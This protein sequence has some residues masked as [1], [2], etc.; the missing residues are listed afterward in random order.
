MFSPAAERNKEPIFKVLQPRLNQASRLL[1]IACGSLQ[2][3]CYMAPQLP[4]LEWLPTDI[5]QEALKYG[6]SLTSRPDSVA[7]PVY[8]DVHEDTWPI[9]DVDAV[10]AAN[11]L[12][13]SPASVMAALFEGCGRALRPDGAV[14]LYGP[15]KQNGRYTSPGDA[16]F[17][18]NLQ[19]RNPA[20]GI[21]NLEDVLSAAQAAG[22][23]LSEQ[24]AMPANNWLLTF[25]R[26]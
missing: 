24:T 2:H 13:I 6:Q 25:R 26:E 3:A 18:D 19:S 11:L 15:F 14:H 16:A 22:I 10:Y 21:R 1:E 9:D 5:D 17:D 8:L 12:H 20:W 7:P 4:A 23:R